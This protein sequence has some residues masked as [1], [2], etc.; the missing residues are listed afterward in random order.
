VIS[1]LRLRRRLAFARQMLAVVKSGL[2]VGSA[3][4]D[5]G[6]FR[7]RTLAFGRASRSLRDG[8]SLGEA[9]QTLGEFVDPLTRALLSGAEQTGRL[10]QVLTH[11]VQQLEEIKRGVGRLLVFSAYPLYLLAGLVFVG[12]LLSLPGSLMGGACAG[13]MGQLYVHGLVQNL[14]LLAGAMAAL[15]CA[16]LLSA[17]LGLEAV[18]DRVVLRLPLWG[19]LY[20]C[21]YGARL[22]AALGSGL[23]AGLDVRRVLQ[24]G[25]QAMASP[26]RSPLV[27]EALTRLDRGESMASALGAFAIFDVPILGQVAVGERTGTLETSFAQISVDQWEAAVGR[28][29]VA[30]FV[31]LGLVVAGFLAS[32]VVKMLGVILGT[33]N[34]AYTLPEKL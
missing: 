28:A 32:A 13:S 5:L 11:R 9:L 8:A 34:R 21:L 22:A 4:E 12:P 30:A 16:P 1:A 15:F 23:G 29:R 14:A 31:V 26:S 3:I 19:R 20:Q 27:T 6:R 18:V 25:A 2:P 10:E 7:G 24:L 33:V 17:L